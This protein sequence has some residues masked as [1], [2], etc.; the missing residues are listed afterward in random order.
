MID[1]ETLT[2]YF[3]RY[4]FIGLDFETF[5]ITVRSSCDNNLSPEELKK[6][7]ENLV[8]N[9]TSVLIKSG[10]ETV[11]SIFNKAVKLL[12]PDDLFA[13]LDKLSTSY[14]TI[15]SDEDI[16]Y[17][18]DFEVLDNF[19]KS[20]ANKYEDDENSDESVLS[21]ILEI[22][23]IAKVDSSYEYSYSKDSFAQTEREVYKIP[24]LTPDQEHDLF[25]RLKNGEDV[26]EQIIHGNLRLLLKVAKKYKFTHTSLPLALG[27]L[28][29]E[30][31]AGLSTAVDRFDIDKGYKFS[32]YAVKWIQQ[33][34]RQFAHKSTRNIV[35]SEAKLSQVS[36][37]ARKLNELHN[38]GYENLSPAE[39]AQLT[40]YTEEDATELM[41]LLLDTA[42][43]DARSEGD[44]GERDTLGD[45]ISSDDIELNPEEKVYDINKSNDLYNAIG[46]LDDRSREIVLHYYG[47]ENRKILRFEELGK[48]F[49]VSRETIRHNLIDALEI[50]RIILRKYA[51]DYDAEPLFKNIKFN[52]SKTDDE[53]VDLHARFAKLESI[54][55]KVKKK[56][57]DVTILEYFPYQYKLKIRCNVCGEEYIVRPGEL[58]TTTFR[59]AKC[60]NLRKVQKYQEQIDKINPNIRIIEYE[61][62]RQP[63]RFRCREC[64]SEW[65][66][67]LNAVLLNPTCVSCD[68]LKGF[69]RKK[70]KNN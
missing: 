51:S 55:E 40:D 45:F 50:L 53:N 6:S 16:D 28:F 30:G 15:I 52:I 56:K 67:N 29:S 41:R 32:T 26:K 13:F 5:C 19:Y 62:I 7:I 64:G 60:V 24:V 61:K 4:K 25:T 2:Y 21:R 46:F 57:V 69:S 44:D 11:V 36:K 58:T 1:N 49:G 22:Y 68:Y 70:D 65:V 31:Y 8:L 10:T 9:Y 18:C 23:D 12:N 17:M 59:C 35:I 48:M 27:D 39:I 38:L 34:M 43:L 14:G 66:S 63:A 33:P 3:R 20:F 42:S 37:F 54:L 47:L